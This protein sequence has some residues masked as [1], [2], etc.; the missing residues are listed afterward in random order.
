MALGKNRNFA[1]GISRELSYQARASSV[2][3][4][5]YGKSAVWLILTVKPCQVPNL[6]VKN[7]I[8]VLKQLTGNIRIQM[9]SDLIH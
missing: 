6:T 8:H 2:K 3:L 4:N 9:L 1:R 7:G 5:P